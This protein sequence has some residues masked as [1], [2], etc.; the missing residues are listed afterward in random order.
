MD[1]AFTINP[2]GLEGLG[3]TLTS[4]IRNCRE[5]SNLDLWF[6]C[7]DCKKSHKSIIEDLL[8][9]ENFKGR[10]NYID[11]N[12]KE[13][14]GHLRSLHGDWTSYG[15]LLIPDYIKSDV[16]LY[17]D[18]DLII[19]IDVLV[20]IGFDFGGKYLAAVPGGKVKYALE[21]NFFINSLKVSPEVD[22]FNAGVLL[23]NLPQWRTDEIQCKWKDIAMEY[24][25][26]LLAVDQ[27]LLN[28]VCKGA[29]AHLPPNFNT[30][31]CPGD[32]KP[33]NAE[34]SIL[35]FVGSPK[36]WDVFGKTLHQ[37][38]DTWKEYNTPGWNNEFNGMTWNK[39]ARTWKIKNS[40]FIKMKEKYAQGN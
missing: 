34:D 17:L 22:Y 37:G 6:F 16:V 39:M 23:M 11:F 35:H 4:L 14:F 2:L 15:R 8:K 25:N 33:S 1:V 30:A 36:P 24:P 18:A 9:N 38:Y 19:L 3:S 32:S 21:R 40:I 7:S 20:L 31:W 12:A 29:F 13:I 28:A 5:T 26:D 27:T 10:S